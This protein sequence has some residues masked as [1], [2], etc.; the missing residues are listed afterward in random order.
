[1]PTDVQQTLQRIDARLGHLEEIAEVH[2]ALDDESL[3][4]STSGLERRLSFLQ[5]WGWLAGVAGV[6]FSAGVGYALFLGENATDKEVSTAVSAG[7]KEHNG[8]VDPSETDPATGYPR[9]HHP[10]MRAAIKSNAEGNRKLTDTQTT[11]GEIIEKLDKRGRYQ[12]EF[13]KWEV[14]KA[15]CKRQRNCT[16]QDLKKPKA[17]ETLE[18]E[19][20]ND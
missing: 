19:L 1:M 4:A 11:Q 3:E 9:G 18:T 2:E 20:I 14:L 16:R 8:R 5:R 12:F 15:E 7:I 13:T 10:D 6:L 17:L